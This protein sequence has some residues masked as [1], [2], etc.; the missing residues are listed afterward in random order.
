MRLTQGG[1]EVY[2]EVETR[3]FEVE[4]RWIDVNLQVDLRW[5]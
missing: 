1:F 2:L 5:F 3:S 4:T